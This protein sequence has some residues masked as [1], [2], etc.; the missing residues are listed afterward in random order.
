MRAPSS[1]L[2]ADVV[3]GIPEI[4]VGIVAPIMLIGVFGLLSIAAWSNARRREREA[5]YRNEMLKKVAESAGSADAVLAM[6]REQE[7]TTRRRRREGEKFGG[8]VAIATGVG[9]M[10]FLR[11]VERREPIFLVGL[12]PL[13]V[14]VAM[15]AYAYVV[16]ERID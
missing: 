3:N 16:A 14:G 7:R 2:E 6:I 4:V 11:A 1:R 13:L 5:L 15:L 9:I 10:V 12:I 8:L